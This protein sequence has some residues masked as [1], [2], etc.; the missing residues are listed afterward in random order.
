[1]SYLLIGSVFLGIGA[2]ASTVREV[3]TLSM[4]VTMAQMMIFALAS[5]G[6]GHPNSASAIAGAVFPSVVAVR[7]VRP[8]RRAAGDH[9]ASR[10]VGCGRRCGSR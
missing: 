5:L 7:D 4:P 6:V 1:M 10:G 3:Q 2:Q 9:A 8:R